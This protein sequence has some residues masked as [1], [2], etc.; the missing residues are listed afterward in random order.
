MTDHSE[1]SRPQHAA[2]GVSGHPEAIRVD[3]A[4]M[5][6]HGGLSA[7]QAVRMWAIEYVLRRTAFGKGREDD[8]FAYA[9]KVTAYVMTGIPC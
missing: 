5:R 8:L 9:D 1:T 3:A 6:S 7:E 2:E 4:H